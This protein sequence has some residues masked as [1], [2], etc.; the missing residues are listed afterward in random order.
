MTPR[1]LQGSGGGGDNAENSDSLNDDTMLQSQTPTA[2]AT[3]SRPQTL[4]FRRKNYSE[5]GRQKF[6]RAYHVLVALS[7][8][9]FWSFVSIVPVYNKFYFQKSLYPYPIATAGIQLGFVSILLAVLNI[10]QHLVSSN[11]NDSSNAGETRSWI[12]GPHFLWKVK[13]CFP[14]GALFGMKY[15]ITNL[16]LH[17]VPAPT[18]LLLQS[19]DLVWTVLG[20]YII[21]AEVVSLVELFC[22]GGCIAGSVVLGLSIESSSLSAPLFA[23]LINL[24]SP[25]LLGLCLATLRL[26][27]T[28]LMRP[29]N[30]V[31]GTVSSV[32][33]TS[34]KLIVSSSVALIL[35]CMMEGG[36]DDTASWWVAFIELERST[37]L[38]V[39]GGAVLI[40]IFQV[41]CTF[42]TFLCT[43]VAVGLVGQV[44]I[45][46]Q[47]LVA[48]FLASRTTGFKVRNM[49]MVGAVFI[50]LSAAAFAIY[51]Y[52]K[53]PLPEEE[54]CNRD[55]E[56]GEKEHK[57]NIDNEGKPLLLLRDADDWGASFMRKTY[58]SVRGETFEEIVGYGTSSVV[59]E[60]VPILTRKTGNQY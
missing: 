29:D 3:G 18:H 5:L 15:G 52:V 35:A 38:G 36:D 56:S 54:R 50:M 20:A 49:N 46:P 60:N 33:L 13:W 40:A 30:R 8:F 58:D 45:I 16:G 14:I 23:I 19:T 39:I 1:A 55:E 11:R 37:Q 25:I 17:L 32:E 41:N 2:S 9:I 7:V 57:T 34:I 12:F 59:E 27:C 24:T 31:S 53:S 51:N 47:W 22:L 26:A 43:A 42:L 28:E 21:N 10:F 6:G 4:G 44:K 48:T